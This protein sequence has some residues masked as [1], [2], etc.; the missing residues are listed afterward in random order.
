MLYSNPSVKNQRFLTPP[1]AEGGFGAYPLKNSSWYYIG[2]R[3]ISHLQH[4]LNVLRHAVGI[5][6][7]RNAIRYS[8]HFINGVGHR[9]AQAAHF[10]RLNV[11]IVVTEISRFCARAISEVQHSLD[12]VPLGGSFIHDLDQMPVG[13]R[14]IQI[15]HQIR[16]DGLQRFLTAEGH[17]YF[18]CAFPFS[19]SC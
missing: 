8:L 18:Q 6:A 11:I 16:L 15:I 5:V 7:F 2:E 17:Q 14:I 13:H 12:A 10:D 9:N 19:N 4:P 1:S 3:F